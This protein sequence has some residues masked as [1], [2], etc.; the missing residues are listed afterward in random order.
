MALPLAV[1]MGVKTLKVKPNPAQ[2]ATRHAAYSRNEV[3][4]RRG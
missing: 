3:R 2:T 4:R 1:E